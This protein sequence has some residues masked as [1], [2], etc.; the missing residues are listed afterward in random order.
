MSDYRSG[1]ANESKHLFID[2][3]IFPCQRGR[4]DSVHYPCDAAWYVSS[5]GEDSSHTAGLHQGALFVPHSIS[6]GGIRALY[7]ETA[8]ERVRE[9][10][11]EGMG[12]RG[13][14]S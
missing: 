12:G 7:G 10:E 8:T 3:F 9:E 5:C 1:R 6:L 2:V 11:R 4:T 13:G 14:R